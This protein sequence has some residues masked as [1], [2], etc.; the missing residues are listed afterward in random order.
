V[1]IAAGILQKAGLIRYARGRMLIAD[2]PS[3]EAAT[4]EC[5]HVVRHEFARLLGPGA[6]KPPG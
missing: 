3:L 4:C 2:R 1:S 5:Y 6:G